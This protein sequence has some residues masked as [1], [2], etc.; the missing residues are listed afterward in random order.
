MKFVISNFSVITTLLQLFSSVSVGNAFT[1]ISSSSS[2]YQARRSELVVTRANNNDNN[3]E[4][5]DMLNGGELVSALARIDRAWNDEQNNPRS[6]KKS[7]WT[8]IFLEKEEEDDEFNNDYTMNA[9][10]SF[11]A[12]AAISVSSKLEEGDF[13][14]LLEPPNLSTPSCL[15]CFLGGAGLGQFP[16]IAYDEFLTRVSNKLNAAVL[17]APYSVGLDHWDLS[18]RTGEILR[19][20]Q[21]QCQDE[22]QYPSSLKT[23]SIS[24]SLGCKLSALYMSATERD[25]DGVGFISFNNFGFSETIRLVREFAQQMKKTPGPYDFM[26]D[27]AV[28]SQ[29]FTFA[30]TAVGALGFDFTP[31]SSEFKKVLEMKYAQQ[32]NASKTRLFVVDNDSLDTSQD[33]LETV[34][35]KVEVSNL[36]GTHLSPVYIK[37]SL[38]DLLNEIDETTPDGGPNVRDFI[39]NQE[40]ASS[41][42]GGY[43]GASFG[44]EQDVD[45]LVQQVVDFVMGKPP[46]TREPLFLTPEATNNS[47][48][49]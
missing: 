7:R 45:V 28:I 19:K 3:N 23:Y 34:G 13:C 38:D 10:G 27:D 21:I 43:Q 41:F 14:Y 47:N 35:R 42:T 17:A 36:S 31:T 8:K 9:D 1:I 48:D 32:E 20:A 22:K 25:Y 40:A 49:Q 26:M 15:I 29:L 24:H 18:K 46:T 2:S 11:T 44:E 12:A 16:H 39:G 30:E 5:N 33:V 4:A 37:L 6:K